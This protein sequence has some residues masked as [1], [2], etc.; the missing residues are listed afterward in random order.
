MLLLIVEHQLLITAVLVGCA[1]L[2]VLAVLATA[3]RE[4]RTGRHS[5]G[6]RRG[7]PAE[8][9]RHRPTGPQT[10]AGTRSVRPPHPSTS[11]VL[12]ETSADSISHRAGLRYEPTVDIR[13][14]IGATA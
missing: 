3:R 14:L 8:I 10:R 5:H 4:A 11:H 9:R 13:A 7:T 1:P 12:D 6:V 2:A